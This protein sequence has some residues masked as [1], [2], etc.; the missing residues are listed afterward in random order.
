MVGQHYFRHG[1]FKEAR[2]AALQF[3]K[4][5]EQRSDPRA[6]G[7][8]NFTLSLAELGYEAPEAALARAEDCVRFA[9]TPNEQRW[10]AG[11][12]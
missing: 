5:G 12:S 4:W 2:E 6:I 1:L 9:V 10:G 8:A 3:M 11:L 7:L